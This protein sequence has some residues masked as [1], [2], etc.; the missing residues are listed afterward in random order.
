MRNRLFKKKAP[1][2]YSALGSRVRPS[3]PPANLVFADIALANQV[4]PSAPPAHLVFAGQVRPSAPP[5][6]LVF[7]TKINSK[8]PKTSNKICNLK[9]NNKEEKENNPL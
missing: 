4:R 8:S 2:G 3:A 1:R 9:L 7:G 5:A 6:D